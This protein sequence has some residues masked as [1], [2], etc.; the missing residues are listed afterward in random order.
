VGAA[1]EVA[2]AVAAFLVDGAMAL[3][4]ALV[5]SG[6]A[7]AAQIAAVGLLRPAMS[8]GQGEFSRR[9]AMG[10][11]IRGASFAVVAVIMVVLKDVLPPAWTAAGYLTVLLSLLLTETRFLR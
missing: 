4:A 2:V 5:G 3:V 11:A 7:L 9:W 8:A 10:M 6:P 1:V